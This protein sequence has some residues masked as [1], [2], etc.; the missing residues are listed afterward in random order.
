LPEMYVQ[1]INLESVIFLNSIYFYK[2]VFIKSLLILPSQFCDFTQ[3]SFL[4]AYHLDLRINLLFAPIIELVP[5]EF[6]F[7]SRKRID[8][9]RKNC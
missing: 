7:L 5:W 3:Q 4:S 2:S 9:A 6:V 1:F 8:R